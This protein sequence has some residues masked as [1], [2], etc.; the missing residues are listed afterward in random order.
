VI[1][2]AI[3]NQKGG[4]GKTTTAVTLAHGLA[5]KNYNVLLIDLDP[6]GQCAT[7]LGLEQQDAVFHLF[8]SH[9]PLRDVVRT[10]GR[11]GLW[12]IPGSKKTKTAEGVMLLERQPVS[13]LQSIL[14]GKINGDQ[15]HYVVLD[16]APSAGGLQEN[17]LYAADLLI[18]PCAVDHLSLEGAGEVLKTLRSLGRAAPPAVRLLPTFFDDVTRESQVNLK[19]LQETFREIVL[20][21]IHRAVALRECPALG[22]TVFEHQ[23]DGRAAEE[24]ARLTWEVLDVKR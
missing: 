17:A 15:L 23:P 20:P 13:T 12:L 9:P 18:I 21:P 1:A 16:T 2:I 19:Q 8:I 5:L 24:Y 7:S 6:Q 3:A 11:P 14:G 22:Q 4:V 10:T